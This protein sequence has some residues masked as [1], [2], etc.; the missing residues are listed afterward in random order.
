[1]GRR[2]WRRAQRRRVIM[3]RIQIER[4]SRPVKYAHSGSL[5]LWGGKTSRGADRRC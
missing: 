3:R 4:S 2:T 1:M 5:R